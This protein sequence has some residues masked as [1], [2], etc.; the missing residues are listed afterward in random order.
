MRAGLLTFAVLIG[1][2][3]SGCG[4]AETF[5]TVAD[6]LYA[7]AAASH[8]SVTVTLPEGA[9]TPVAQGEDGQIYI[10]EDYEISLQTLP[11]GDM[12]RTIKSVSGYDRQDL[13]VLQQEGDYR[14]CDFVWT[15][16]GEQGVMIGRAAVLDDGNYH[17]VLTAMCDALDAGDVRRDWDTVFQS[18]SLG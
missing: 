8:G 14:R 12:G 7:E 1:M 13:T 6:V 3:L 10:C 17:Y 5:E 18:F 15:S 11:G 4:E 16:A 2:V 9:V